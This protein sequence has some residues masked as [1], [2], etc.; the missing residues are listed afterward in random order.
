MKAKDSNSK[1]CQFEKF[2]LNNAVDI[3]MFSSEALFY[4][5]DQCG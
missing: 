4:S 1:I 2:S 3:I 5:K